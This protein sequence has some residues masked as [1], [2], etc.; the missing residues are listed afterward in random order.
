MGAKH[1]LLC[2]KTS[3]GFEEIPMTK[4]YSVSEYNSAFSS[5]YLPTRKQSHSCAK[6]DYKSAVS[7]FPDNPYQLGYLKELRELGIIMENQ[8]EDLETLQGSNRIITLVKKQMQQSSKESN[9]QEGFFM[10]LEPDEDCTKKDIFAKRKTS[11]SI[12]DSQSNERSSKFM[13]NYFEEKCERR[14]TA[15]DLF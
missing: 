10:N 4:N 7:S 14:R 1:S 6:E 13:K 9:L 15:L 12:E 8:E 11:C 2:K 3:K 5:T